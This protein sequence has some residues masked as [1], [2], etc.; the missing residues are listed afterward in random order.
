MSEYCP[1]CG[2]KTSEDDGRLCANCQAP[3]EL[4]PAHGSASLFQCPKCDG[5][6]FNI[7]TDGILVCA[8]V[9]KHTDYKVKHGGCGWRGTLN[10]KGQR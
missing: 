3:S 10:E 1:K 5:P 9:S 4:P 8:S 7:G 6:H 2:E